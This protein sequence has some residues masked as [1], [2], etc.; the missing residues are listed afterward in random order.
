MAPRFYVREDHN[1]SRGRW[2]T[3]IV[4]VDETTDTVRGQFNTH[5]AAKEWADTL[6]NSQAQEATP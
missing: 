3:I 4:V 1:I 6:N 5:A 2:R